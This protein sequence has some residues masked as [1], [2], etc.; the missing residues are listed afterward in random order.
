[1]SPATLYDDYLYARISEDDIG[2]EKGVN[3][4][5]R[6]GRQKSAGT[7]GRIVG[8]FYDNDISALNM[9]P[10]PQFE[11]LMAAVTA[12]NPER[13]QRRII[14][15][16]T[17]RVWR[18]RTERAH[19]IDTLGKAKIVVVPIDGPQLDLTTAAGRMV[20]GMLGEV[21]T[22]ESETKGERIMDSARER[23]QEG[24]ANG[25][26]LYGWA[27]VYQYDARGKVVGFEDVVNEAEAAVVR[28][29]VTR[30]LRG[31]SVVGVTRNLN[32]RGIPAPSAGDRRQ[33]RALGQ[34]ENGTRWGR[35]SV[36]KIAIRPANIGMRIYHRG[37]D[38]EEL[39]PAAWPR[40]IE[41]ADHD[42]VVALLS[43]PA[44]TV[45]RPGS[46]QHL[47]TWGIGKCGVCDGHLRMAKRGNQRYGRKHVLYLCAEHSCVGRDL[48]RVDELVTEVMVKLLSQPDAAQLLAGSSPVAAQAMERASDLRRRLKAVAMQYA[49]GLIEEDQLRIITGQ[50]KPQ[51]EEA[52]AVAAANR[53][54]PFA[55]AAE[56]MMGEQAREHWAAGSVTQRRAAIKAFGV[57]VII[58]KALKRGP[59]FDPRT[60]RV[61]PPTSITVA[62]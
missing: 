21:D 15:Q 60:V 31:E 5:L 52:K 3:R 42:R 19:G 26:V 20:A 48:E 18:N 55:S 14:C 6:N 47:L 27:R 62:A 23:A 39:M 33:K 11:M 8:E 13:R 22:G 35:T 58:D 54:S 50:L 12:P 1:M 28:E 24:R 59:G 46:R 56:S 41:L 2:T 29:I 53:T 45:E 25:A 17:S 36:T 16:H 30:L 7:G 61:T 43:D 40:L 4:Q 32:E 37:R 51:L 49:D 44:R 10:R 57:T 34:D 9:A 38:D